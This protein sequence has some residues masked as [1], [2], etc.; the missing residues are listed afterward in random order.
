MFLL[1]QD[2]ISTNCAVDKHTK[3]LV[4]IFSTNTQKVKYQ[5]IISM[6][7]HISQYLVKQRA[8]NRLL[9]KKA[10]KLS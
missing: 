8:L 6:D 4:E 5:L 10:T 9:L 2:K 3:V 7:Q 1:N